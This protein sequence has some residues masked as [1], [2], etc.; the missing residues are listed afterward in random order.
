MRRTSKLTLSVPEDVI[1]R[2][3][4]YARLHQTTVSA[5]VTRLFQSL[6]EDTKQFD[7][8]RRRRE[9]ALVTDSCVGL[10]S[11]PEANKADLI[12][13]AIADK[14]RRRK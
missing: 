11:V 12:S 6:K 10:I 4:A 9:A 3:K 8:A 13:Q 14:Y 1:R 7:R 5:L 2:A